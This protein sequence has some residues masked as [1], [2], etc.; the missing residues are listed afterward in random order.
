MTKLYDEEGLLK[1]KKEKKLFLTLMIVTIA[2]IVSAFICFLF[3]FIYIS[4][5]YLQKIIKSNNKK[6]S[7]TGNFYRKI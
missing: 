5:I 4:L 2:L 6:C 1:I 7:A 3:T